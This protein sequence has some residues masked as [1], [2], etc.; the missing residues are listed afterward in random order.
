MVSMMKAALYFPGHAKVQQAATEA[1]EA[2][3][4][5]AEP[6]DKLVLGIR[7]R[8]L[9]H[10]GRPLYDLSLYAVRLIDALR[11][12]RA[13]GVTFEQGVTLGEL[14]SLIEFL[15]EK[16]GIGNYEEAEE[17]LRSKGVRNVT[18]ARMPAEALSG[19]ALAGMLD[20]SGV[21]QDSVSFL[22][23]MVIET[24]SGRE[25]DVD[26]TL[27]L[28]ESIV[29]CVQEKRDEALSFTAFK[30]YD[31]YTYNHSVNVCILT[32]AL[33]NTLTED[34]KLLVRVGEAA[35][36]HDVGKIF[37]PEE[38]LYK[39]GK[40]TDE[41]YEMVRMH[42]E[43]GAKYLASLEG[44]HS[45]SVSAAYGHH[46]GYDQSGYPRL[47]EKIY[48]D[49]VTQII[50]LVD[51]YE[52]LTSK[53]PYKKS[54]PCDQAASILI[55]GAG[56]QFNPGLVRAFVRMLGVYP[57]GSQVRLTSGETA[58]V[59]AIE[60]KNLERP[61]VLVVSDRDG[62]ELSEPFAVDTSA[63]DSEGNF[64]YSIEKAVPAEV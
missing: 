14:I 54:T 31:E 18:L 12:R 22:Q 27:G 36:L 25:F 20:T 49:P 59:Q 60:P 8:Q 47:K 2:I 52:A 23:E 37:V 46:L 11:E 17:R 6:E 15:G 62:K 35:L 40:L 43:R 51:V 38:V 44:V 28:A 13:H 61:R 48:V 3:R 45:L 63:I 4:D 42:P 39:P 33:A 34:K 29:D 41:E 16:G 58:I 57:P 56:K 55:D 10:A 9:I 1:L 30:D 19:G 24:A 53:R 64:V 21:Y 5:A 32:V 7:E 26:K 50:N